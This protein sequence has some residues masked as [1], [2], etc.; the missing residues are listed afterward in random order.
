[1]KTRNFIVTA[2]CLGT[3][4]CMSVFCS[5]IANAQPRFDKPHGNNPPNKARKN[6]HD[7]D[8]N[9]Q[10]E[11]AFERGFKAG[12][13]SSKKYDNR[14]YNGERKFNRNKNY[15]GKYNSK[16]NFRNDF[17][18]GSVER[19]HAFH[20]SNPESMKHHGNHDFHKDGYGNF[21]P[22]KFHGKG[23]AQVP[24]DKFYREFDRTAPKNFHKGEFNPKPFGKQRGELAR[25]QKTNKKDFAPP[26]KPKTERNKKDMPKKEKQQKPNKPN[27]PVEKRS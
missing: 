19:F 20:E 26:T 11:A 21:A 10:L 27:V 18:R 6:I 1:M 24:S 17:R 15:Q 16:K 9:R 23:F 12:V 13:E 7:V 14:R 3:V 22:R 8:F 5:G 2:V 4:I 25:G